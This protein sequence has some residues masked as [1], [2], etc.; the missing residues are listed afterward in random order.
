[1]LFLQLTSQTVSH[2]ISS[3][4]TTTKAKNYASG[5]HLLVWGMKQRLVAVS[6]GKEGWAQ[7]K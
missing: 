5:F 2:S 3:P 6:T 4:V 1:L 7:A